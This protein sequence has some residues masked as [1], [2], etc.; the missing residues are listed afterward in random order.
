MSDMERGLTSYAKWSVLFKMLDF[1]R[2]P[3]A[4]D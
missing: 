1:D 4:L 3:M 2:Q